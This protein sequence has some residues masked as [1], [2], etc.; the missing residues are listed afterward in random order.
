MIPSED[1]KADFSIYQHPKVVCD[2]LVLFPIVARILDSMLR[3][4]DSSYQVLVHYLTTINLDVQSRG[5]VAKKGIRKL[6]FVKVS[7]KPK[8]LKQ[9]KPVPVQIKREVT[10]PVQETIAKEFQKEV[11][12]SKP[13]ILKQTK[14]NAHILDTLLNHQLLKTC[15]HQKTILFRR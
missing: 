13:G 15:L 11:F 14:K 3:K 8:N 10:K 7:K 9:P 6:E 2:D 1:A 12:P 4:V 5:F